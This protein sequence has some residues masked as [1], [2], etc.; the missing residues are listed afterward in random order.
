ML[1]EVWLC[2][3]V[4]RSVPGGAYGYVG[5]FGSCALMREEDVRNLVV[6]ALASDAW[7]DEVLE[8]VQEGFAA[9]SENKA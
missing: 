3:S 1:K 8:G 6:A 4:S 2:R 9:A 5:R 7:H